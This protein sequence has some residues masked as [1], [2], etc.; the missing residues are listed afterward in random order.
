MLGKRLQSTG[1]APCCQVQGPWAQAS[2]GR[3]AQAGA[4]PVQALPGRGCAADC[5]REQRP[6]P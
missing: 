5:G 1:A 3:P 6:V 2:G 4:G